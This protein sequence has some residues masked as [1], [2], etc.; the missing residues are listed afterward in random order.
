MTWF[1]LR[2][3]CSSRRRIMSLVTPM[4]FAGL[5]LSAVTLGVSGAV[6][7]QSWPDKTVRVIVPFGPGG[8]TDIQGRLLGKKFYESMKQTFVVDNRAGAAG[9]IG[10]EQAVRSPPDGYTELFTTASLSVN[11]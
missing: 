4:R 2:A 9:L 8:G 3:D 6:L 5:L 7:A 10:A 11:V 1:I